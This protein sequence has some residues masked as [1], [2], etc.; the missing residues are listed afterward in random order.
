MRLDQRSITAERTG[1]ASARAP[2]PGGRLM[3]GGLYEV[4][5]RPRAGARIFGVCQ[6]PLLGRT[7]PNFRQTARPYSD[8]ARNRDSGGANSARDASVF[9]RFVGSCLHHVD[10]PGGFGRKVFGESN[11]LSVFFSGGPK[12]PRRAYRG[13]PRRHEGAPR[14]TGER[15]YSTRDVLST[16]C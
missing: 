3:G 10:G 16:R 5:W 6:R 7:K 9:L 15:P 12:R 1:V 2:S 4:V 11:R 8:A 14:G 13:R